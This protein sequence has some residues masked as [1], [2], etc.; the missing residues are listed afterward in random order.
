MVSSAAAG[1][2]SLA[3]RAGEIVAHA[4]A[5]VRT[6]RIVLAVSACFVLIAYRPLSGSASWWTVGVV[7]VVI[8]LAVIALN[9]IS[10][11]AQRAQATSKRLTAL[12][13]ALDVGAT[14]AL[15]LALDAP[16]RG[17]AWVLLV[18]PVVSGLIRLG[19]AVSMFSWA[20]GCALYAAL[21]LTGVV[22]TATSGEFLIRTSG[23][24]LAVAA[25]IGILARWM[26]EGWEIQNELTEAASASAARLATV[27]TASRAMARVPPEDALKA[28]LAYTLELGFA[29]ATIRAP[30]AT[31][32]GVVVGRADLVSEPDKP[33]PVEPGEVALTTWVEGG[34]AAAHSASAL[35]SHTSAVVT[36]WSEE[37]IDPQQADALSTLVAQASAAIETSSLLAQ[38]REEAAHDPLTGLANRRVFEEELERQAASEQEIAVIFIDV[39]HFKSINDKYG[40]LVGD[41]IL[42]ATAG[43]LRSSVRP[44]DLVA[45]IGGDEFV[46]LFRQIAPS[47]ALGIGEAIVAAMNVP[48]ALSG[49]TLDVHI[50]VGLGTAVG[51]VAAKDLLDTADRAVYQAKEAGRNRLAH[52]AFEP[53]EARGLDRTH[54]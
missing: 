52:V 51:P 54:G 34:T 17:E 2:A 29:T 49:A 7:P 27:E 6:T 42:T 5:A 37:Q 20:G 33:E 38:I 1:P 9:A 43:R 16:L 36:G 35:E 40:H 10:V 47:Q 12:S 23:I 3:G 22:T 41:E 32:P 11:R 30:H 8:A 39:D 48:V 44:T 14:V 15:V 13:Q 18:I 31:R 28:C 21:T 24:L 25:T 45:R 19:A 46:I 26:R 53:G 50:S 4:E